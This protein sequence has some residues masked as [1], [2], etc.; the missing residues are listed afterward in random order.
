MKALLLLSLI[1]LAAPLIAAVPQQPVMTSY[2]R[3]W[4]DS[5]FTAKPPPA[6]P[7]A[8]VNPFEGFSLGGVS[9]VQGGY[10]VIILHDKDPEKKT[11][12]APGQKSDWEILQVEWSDTF[13]KETKVRVRH[14][15]KEGVLSFDEAQ[16]TLASAPAPQPQQNRGG[17]QGAQP[18]QN[19]PIPQMPGGGRPRPR[20]VVPPPN[21]GQRR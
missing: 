9:R 2:S 5:P 18:G 1:A 10:F 6:T 17:P 15:G 13:W 7:T 11:T 3:L 12:V 14:G 19:N 4:T 16:L 20:V 8:A 21:P